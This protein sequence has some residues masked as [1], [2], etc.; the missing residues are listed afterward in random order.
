MLK[1]I[2]S[3]TFPNFKSELKLKSEHGKMS[4]LHLT[5]KTQFPA[6]Q[7]VFIHIYS[8]FSVMYRR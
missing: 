2:S 7:G 8:G 6:P 1:S 4:P 3:L 5:T